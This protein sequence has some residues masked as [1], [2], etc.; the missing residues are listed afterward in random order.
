M[1][2]EPTFFFSNPDASLLTLRGTVEKNGKT[3]GIS[4]SCQLPEE[5]DKRAR[6]IADAAGTLAA[7]LRGELARS[8]ER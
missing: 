5:V 2:R 1:R 7:M 6:A 4:V 3:K 8:K